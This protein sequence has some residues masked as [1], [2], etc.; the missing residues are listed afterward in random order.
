MAGMFSRVHELSQTK[1]RGN[2]SKEVHVSL[3]RRCGLSVSLRVKLTR[4]QLMLFE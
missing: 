2:M 4:K 3:F 1:P